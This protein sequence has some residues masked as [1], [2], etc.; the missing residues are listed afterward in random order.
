MKRSFFGLKNLWIILGVVGVTAGASSWFFSRPEGLAS[1]SKLH[2]V[3]SEQLREAFRVSFAT[4]SE[5]RDQ[6]L[7][8]V[9]DVEVAANL[10]L[11]LDPLLQAEMQSLF[12][13]YRP[14]YGAFVAMDPQTGKILAMVSHVE[15]R[16]E[17]ETL[18]HM[19][20][21][22]TFPSASIFKVVTAAAAIAEREYSGNTVISFTGG[23]HSLYK[24]HVLR[25]NSPSGSRKMT[26]REAFGRSV[27]TVFGRIG[28]FTLGPERLRDY[29]ERFGFNRSI[30]SDLPIQD[31]VARIDDDSWSLA[32]SAS[33]YTLENRM[34]PLQGALIA[35][36]IANDG[37]MMR[38]YLV[39]SAHRADTGELMYQAAPELF[40]HTTDP[41][42]AGELRE[43]MRETVQ[44]GTS[45][46]SFRGFFRG[47]FAQLDVGGK[48]GSLTGDAPR[49]KYDWFV[50][51][52]EWQGKKIA[53][54]A[55]TV[56]GKFWTVKSS[57]L[58]R[59]SLEGFFGRQMGSKNLSSS[60][61]SLR[62]VSGEN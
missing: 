38:P 20:L 4:S 42:T 62:E 32:E 31:G 57:Y 44:K 21:R 60:S 58:A 2:P 45:R 30:S 54:S 27:N 50:G 24:S 14:D 46:K 36:S 11:T 17:V 41:D 49:G 43:L 13:R 9:G 53:L 8:K 61:G 40:A 5:I 12:G 18:G 3:D 23:N 6:A 26:L 35:A 29:A 10:D 34:S 59:R 56:H 47:K 7:L 25:E 28:A 37:A 51:Y 19:A 16:A 33:G 22:S 15:D 48:T 55:L 1:G 39:E 52:G